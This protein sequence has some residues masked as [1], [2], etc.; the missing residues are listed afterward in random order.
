MR[1]LEK[2]IFFAQNLRMLIKAA[3]YTQ[4]D[5]CEAVGISSTTLRGYLYEDVQPTLIKLCLMSEE[6]H[7]SIDDLVYSTERLDLYYTKRNRTND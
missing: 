6:L 1:K 5:F 4:L 3:G 7:I 2:P